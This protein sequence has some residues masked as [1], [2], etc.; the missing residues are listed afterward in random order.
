M[1]ATTSPQRIG[2]NDV[3]RLVLELFAFV[4]LGIWGFVAFGFPL[5]IVV[6]LGAPAVAILLWALFRSP[7]AV[8]SIDVFG[9]SLVELLVVAAAT[10]AWLD[11]GQPV[12][13]IVYAAVAVVSGVVAGRKELSR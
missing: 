11:L 9:K 1:T 7:K 2:V 13:G 6:G 4:T 10:L 8:F 3:L 5:N 12:V